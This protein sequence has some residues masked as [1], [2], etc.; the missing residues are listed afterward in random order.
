MFVDAGG[1]K[2]DFIDDGH[3]FEIVFEGEIDVGEGLRLHA[4]RR[5]HNEKR[6][7][8]GGKGAG[9]FIGEIHMPG[10]VDEVEFVLLSVEGGIVHSHGRKFDRNPALALDVHAVEK[11]FL[12]IALRDLSRQ[13]HD[14]VGDRALAVVDVSDNAKIS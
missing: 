1:L 13:F 3:D 7:L 11:L 9:D 8:A 14:A 12:H 4:L 2:V 5:V 10:R 6:A